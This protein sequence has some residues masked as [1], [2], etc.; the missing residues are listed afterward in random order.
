VEFPVDINPNIHSRLTVFRSLLL[1]LTPGRLLDLATGHGLFA[2]AAHELGWHVT[3]VDI[4]TARFPSAAGIEWVH[5]DVRSY[6]FTA[7]SFD[8]ITLLGILYHLELPDQ[9]ALLRRCVGTPTI[10]DTHV[11][12]IGDREQN[13]Y[14]GHYWDEGVDVEA[15]RRNNLS[16]WDNRWSWWSTIESTERLLHEAGFRHTFRLSPLWSEERRRAGAVEEAR[17][18]WW[19]L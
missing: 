11:S 2:V 17:T 13:G 19:C 5:A 12:T 1:P 7:A 4:R 3:A 18:W 10:V 14:E 8:V 9:L 16:S 6:A 15:R